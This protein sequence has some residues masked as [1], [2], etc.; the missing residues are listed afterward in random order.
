MKLGTVT[1]AYSFIINGLIRDCEITRT[2][3]NLLFIEGKYEAVNALF[4]KV[5]SDCTDADIVKMRSL[6]NSLFESFERA[7]K[8]AYARLSKFKF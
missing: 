6:K 8:E 2:F 7:R 3:E 1:G 4:V 5:M